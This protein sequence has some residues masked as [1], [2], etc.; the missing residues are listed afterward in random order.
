MTLHTEEDVFGFDV[1]MDHSL[2]VSDGN[3]ATDLDRDTSRDFGRKRCLFEEE[4]PQGDAPNELDD[5]I[6]FVLFFRRNVI[7]LDN[8]RMLD[9]SDGQRLRLKARADFRVLP[10]VS[11]DDLDRHFASQAPIPRSVHSCHPTMADLL[12]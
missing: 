8:V 9:L 6:L 1:P 7:H 2:S 11:V 3:G 10:Q 12:Q 4:L 5:E